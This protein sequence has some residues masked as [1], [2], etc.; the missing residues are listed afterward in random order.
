MFNISIFLIKFWLF[1]YLKVGKCLYCDLIII[2]ICFKMKSMFIILLRSPLIW[3][4]TLNLFKNLKYLIFINR[5]YLHVALTA[6]IKHYILNVILSIMNWISHNFKFVFVVIDV[7]IDIFISLNQITT[8]SYNFSVVGFKFHGFTTLFMFH[9]L[10][11]QCV[12]IAGLV[13]PFDMLR[14]CNKT[15][16]ARFINYYK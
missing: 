1:F 2:S 16:I 11:L 3:G 4:S 12:L 13:R 6:F 15:S 7:L 14:L 5:C 8:Y 10:I 9:L